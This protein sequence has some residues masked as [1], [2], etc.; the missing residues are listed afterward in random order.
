MQPVNEQDAHYY[1]DY[2]LPTIASY[3]TVSEKRYREYLDNLVLMS[4]MPDIMN[5]KYLVLP[6]A[7]YIHQKHALDSK[8]QLVFNSTTGSVVLENSTVLPKAWLVSD[9][10]VI[11]DAKERLAYMAGNNFNPRITG[12]VEDEPPLQLKASSVMP[13]VSVVLYKPNQIT[14]SAT[15]DLPALLVLGEKLYNWWYVTVD[16][17]PT[18]II[19]V[20]HILRGVYLTP[21][22]HT[23][24]FRFDPLPF[25]IGK[26]L[27]LSSFALF[28]VVAIREWLLRR[29]EHGSAA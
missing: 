11:K 13:L 15:A 24:E 3:V 22:K 21:G 23:V 4:A 28:G 29:R 20:N 5:L 27:T 6:A 9:L 14:L 10:R 2:N 17:K 25:K 7:D 19:P 1:S 18:I 16:G 26:W 8:Y 12:V